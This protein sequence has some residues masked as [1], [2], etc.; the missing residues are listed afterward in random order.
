MMKIVNRIAV[1]GLLCGIAACGGNE[2]PEDA[3]RLTTETAQ[4]RQL[5]TKSFAS[6]DINEV[7]GAGVGVMQDFGIKITGTDKELGLLI[8]EKQTE[9][10]HAGEVAGAVA[11]SVLAS[12]LGSPQEAVWNERQKLRASLFIRA[13]SA[14]KIEVRVTFQNIVWDN[15]NRV[16]SAKSV[17]D[18]EI[19]KD[20][21]DKLSK[22]A[23]LEEY[24]L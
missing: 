24:K 20:F 12:A 6:K 21:F 15:H 2:I 4:I 19:Y 3:L 10:N 8:G 17:D 22:A 11:L 5:Q 1:I 18:P 13:V 9:M 7:L 23:F 14:E 16:S